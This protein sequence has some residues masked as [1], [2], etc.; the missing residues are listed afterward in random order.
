[1]KLQAGSRVLLLLLFVP[2]CQSPAESE[3]DR[4][5]P[6]AAAAAPEWV[7]LFNGRD[8][9]GWI[10]KITGFELGTNF[11]DT[12]RVEDGLLRVDYSGY[13]QFDGRFGH[14][15]F[16]Q[17]FDHYDL[18]VTYRFV[19]DQT[20]GGPGWALRNSGVM[21]HG[22]DPKSM[23][24]DQQFPVSIEAQMLGEAA[25]TTALRTNGNLCT[26]GTNVEMGGKLIQ[27]HCINSTSATYRGDEWVTLVLEVRGHES[28]RH[29]IDG[30][31]VLEYQGPQLD[32]RDGDA[33]A[34]LAA[35]APVALSRGWI[36]LQ[37]ESHP[38]DFKTV[39]IR[40]VD[41]R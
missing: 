1:M 41:P 4:L 22:Q 7:P 23:T 2:A 25:E 27:D 30:E 34:L 29:R 19:G 14:L 39:E 12:F 10:P 16:E 40:V 5:E 36:S 21:L 20:S 37:A 15:F 17:P 38:L 18:R 28:I 35:G 33:Q 8:L 11:A 31:V 3:V 24:V 9:D 32:P 13:E 6:A 26:P